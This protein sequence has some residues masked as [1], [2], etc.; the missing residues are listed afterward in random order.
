MLD[1]LLRRKPAPVFPE[2]VKPT[3]PQDDGPEETAPLKAGPIPDFL[4][5]DKIAGLTFAIEY[6]G[7]TRRITLR[8]VDPQDGGYLH[9]MAFCHEAMGLRTFRSDRITAIVDWQ[10]GEVFTDIHR[11]M[12]F[13]IDLGQIG[14]D[15]EADQRRAHERVRL[16]I[17]ILMYLARVDGHVHPA[18]TAVVRTYCQTV[19]ET[20]RPAIKFYNLEKMVAYAERQ[21]PEHDVFRRAANQVATKRWKGLARMTLNSAEQIVMADGTLDSREAEAIAE[22]RKGFGID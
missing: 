13:L 18:E 2:S 19:C 9:I 11:Y 21:Y 6:K 3:P 10:T 4:K 1:F 17:T 16:G 14:E 7:E 5:G 12:A 20:L 22:V 15:P 8:R